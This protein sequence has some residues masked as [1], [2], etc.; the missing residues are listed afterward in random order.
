MQSLLLTIITNYVLI[1]TLV[2]FADLLFGILPKNTLI[3]GIFGGSAKKGKTL[4]LKKLVTLGLYNIQRGVDSC[5]YYYNGNLEKGIDKLANFG[6]FISQKDITKG[7]LPCEVFIGHTR[8]STSGTNTE[9]NAHPH[10]VGNYV[11][12]HN[13]TLKNIW[14]LCNTY[15]VKH[16]HIH[17][18]SIGL[19]SI[20][21]KENNFN[22]LDKYEGY[23]ALAMTWME[24]PN[25]LYLFHGASKEYSAQPVYEERPLF[26]LDTPEG[27][28]YSS[29]K[30]S[31]EYINESKKT[32]VE[33]L[34]HNIV[35]RIEHGINK[36]VIYRA[37]REEANI[38]FVAPKKT[39]VYAPEPTSK[40]KN[41]MGKVKEIN[42]G[43]LLNESNIER[44]MIF[45]ENF[46][47]EAITQDIFYRRSRFYKN[48]NTLLQG[49]YLIDRNGRILLDKDESV[50]VS[51]LY[52]FYR[53]AMLR[54][55]KAYD[56]IM[57][58]YPN[59]LEKLHLNVSYYLS[60]Y[61]KYPICS[62]DGEGTSVSNEYL[63]IW[64]KDG[65][66]IESMF[67][68]KFSTRE[69]TIKSGLLHSVI[70]T[71]DMSPTLDKEEDL[72][73]ISILDGDVTQ[74][75]KKITYALLC[76][77]INDWANKVLVTE[78]LLDIPEILLLMIDNYMET[79]YEQIEPTS[80]C[81]ESETT[82][83]LKD[84]FKSGVTFMDYLT[85]TND[86]SI[87]SLTNIEK[88]FKNY[89]FDEIASLQNRYEYISL[90]ED[91][92]DDD[93]ILDKSLMDEGCP[94]RSES[95][96]DA[97][98]SNIFSETLTEENSLIA[99]EN[100]ILI[101]KDKLDKME[102][103]ADDLQ[104]SESVKSQRKCW[105]MYNT[106]A[107]LKKSLHQREIDFAKRQIN[108]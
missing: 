94:F 7:D 65:I 48:I 108:G 19:A 4:N 33:T 91:E 26:T 46:P 9:E 81:I 27:L 92:I 57:L 18:D 68:P 5:G 28:Y 15:N 70:N 72:K 95:Y 82:V 84:L 80:L 47:I 73:F 49:E 87:L 8:K 10:L 30:E 102:K 104:A 32:K 88:V 58:V 89:T 75:E 50:R 34:P 39:V 36:E 105:E 52:Y 101:L 59:P 14:S 77:T 76:A 56:D 100:E 93:S 1:T 40:L 64:Y 41:L 24:D 29:L 62:I 107:D 67:K 42:F 51:K 21:E 66:R 22:V 25:S 69:Y 96:A 83:A 71:E 97:V 20:I 99:E 38:P 17:V 86:Q 103:E 37:S 85:A 63:R 61:C 60:N 54:D 90:D 45:R 55:K 16:T 43:K 78:Q 12:T 11:Q 53:G 31:L 74:N 2:Y 6:N 79:F 3:C 35:Y 106:I 44:P 13:G 23:A 98:I